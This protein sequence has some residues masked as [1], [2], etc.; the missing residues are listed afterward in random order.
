MWRR[1]FSAF[2]SAVLPR[3]P[4][5]DRALRI[6]LQEI[7][8]VFAP[9][10]LRR[11]TWIHV[12]FPYRDERIRS[13]VQSVKYYGE[14]SVAEKS[15]PFLADYLTELVAHKTQFEG[16]ERVVVVPIPAAPKRLRERGYNQAAL[17]ARAA[18]ARVPDATLDESL[19]T[20]TDRP[21]QVH[22]PRPLRKSN[23]R[24]AFSAAPH[25]QGAFV[26]LIDDVVESSATLTDARRALLTAGAR[27]VVA[28]ALAH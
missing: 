22:V 12:L 21:S 17:W 4:R 26:I 16:W 7:A 3:H 6:P 10:V 1:I 24:G 20:R 8:S 23:M 18:A 15:A 27:D 9:T 2:L 25:A 5:A 14:R 19:L 13:L 11:A 28:I